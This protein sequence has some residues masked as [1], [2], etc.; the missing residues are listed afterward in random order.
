[1]VAV[2]GEK[3]VERYDEGHGMVEDGPENGHGTR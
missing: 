1:V 3:N 2:G